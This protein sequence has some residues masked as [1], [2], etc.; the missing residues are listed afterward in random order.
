MKTF[1]LRR[2]SFLSQKQIFCISTDIANFHKVLPKYFKSLE[3]IEDHEYEKIV[4]EKIK[5][6]G[7]S[8]KIRTKHVILP[9]GIHEVHILSGPLKNSSFIE[10]YSDSEKGSVVTID[11]NLKFSRFLS[12]FGFLSGYISRQMVLVMDQFIIAVEENF[13]S[14]DSDFK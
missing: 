14:I 5:F 2:T 12:M 6:L 8:L 10:L 7:F 1:R 9:P 11:V 4:I 3:I 13:N